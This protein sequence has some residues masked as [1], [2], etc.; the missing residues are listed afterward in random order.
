MKSLDNNN[1]PHVILHTAYF[2][3]GLRSSVKCQLVSAP[4]VRRDLRIRGSAR[5]SAWKSFLDQRHERVLRI[6]FAEHIVKMT[7]LF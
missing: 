7:I 5:R 2:Q 1:L 6:C 4:E 3:D